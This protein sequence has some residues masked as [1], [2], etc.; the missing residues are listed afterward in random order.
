M[1]IGTFL[2]NF[3]EQ[4]DDTDASTINAE[5]KFRDIDEWDSLT[6]LSIIAMVDEEYAV[7]LT[8]EDFRNSQTIQDLFEVVKSRVN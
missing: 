2:N 3:I 6:S 5:T 1:E 7:K 8:G 4:L